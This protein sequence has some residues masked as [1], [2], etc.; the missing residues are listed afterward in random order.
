MPS[1]RR[2]YFTSGSVFHCLF[3]GPDG[4][5]VYVYA[6]VEERWSQIYVG[7]PARGMRCVPGCMPPRDY[8]VVVIDTDEVQFRSVAHPSRKTVHSDCPTWGV[9]EL[10]PLNLSDYDITDNP[11]GTPT[12]TK[13]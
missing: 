1:S 2:P 11:R 5:Y 6:D 10:S 7:D 8:G 9:M 12:I 3:I 4:T 13:R